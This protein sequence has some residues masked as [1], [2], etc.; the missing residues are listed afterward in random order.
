MIFKKGL[1]N[2]NRIKLNPS[3]SVI[4]KMFACL[5]IL[6]APR[7]REQILTSKDISTVIYDSID[8]IPKAAV[9]IFH[10]ENRVNGPYLVELS[11][12]KACI[13]AGSLGISMRE[14]GLPILLRIDLVQANVLLAHF[15]YSLSELSTWL[16]ES[17]KIYLIKES[18]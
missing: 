2:E 5:W 10:F 15:E 3:V 9:N 1:M 4:A 6:E 16:R 11:E 17:I 8:S 14:P 13:R 12:I 18:P 7:E